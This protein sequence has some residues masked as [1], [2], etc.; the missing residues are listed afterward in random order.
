MYLI[1][2]IPE[3][4]FVKEIFSPELR[5]RG[6]YSLYRLKKRDYSTVKA[7]QIL[8]RRFRIALK[9]IG[10]AGSK[11]KKAITEQSISLKC[12][13]KEFKEADLE[14]EFLGY[15][16]KPVSLGD[17]E[18]N[19]FE[20]VIRNIDTAPKHF[21]W[22]INYFDDQRFSKNNHLIGKEIVKGRF[23]EAAELIKNE[24]LVNEHLAKDPNDFIGAIKKIPF[25]TRLLY[26][27]SYQSWLWNRAVDRYFRKHPHDTITYSLGD[28]SIPKEKAENAKIPLVGFDV[29]EEDPIIRDLLKEEGIKQ[30]NFVIRSMPELSSEGASRDRV[31]DVKDLVI[32]DLEDDE[33]HPSKKKVKISFNL[34]KGS[35]ATMFVKHL[36][37]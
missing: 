26:V 16:D 33:L 22:M 37:R 1:K 13:R 17:H 32:H 4:F 25:K 14:L 3:D 5:R 8:S 24:K 7:T 23:K 30:K 15:S 34:Q 36:F 35:Y 19:H 29:L 6:R 12:P 9:D 28:V 10:F 21:D 27:H 31:I 2:E 11:D 18:A 20:I